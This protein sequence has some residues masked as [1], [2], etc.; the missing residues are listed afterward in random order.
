M[1]QDRGRGNEGGKG[2]GEGG[3]VVETQSEFP[4]HSLVHVS[5]CLP[6]RV[7]SFTVSENECP[8]S[9]FLDFTRDVVE[10]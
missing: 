10:M 2:E 6:E 8:Q 5:S 7:I 3:A 1:Q 9:L 4:T